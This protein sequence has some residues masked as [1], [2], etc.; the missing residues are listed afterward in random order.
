MAR[1]LILA[2]S[3]F[4][5]TTSIGKIPEFG[6]EGLSPEDTYIISVTSKPL[7]FKGSAT[8]FPIAPLSDLKQGRRVICKDAS[9]VAQ[10][11]NDLAKSPFKNVVWDD[12]NYVMQDWYMDNAL[13]KGW[14]A[15]KQIGFF[16]G[17]IFKAIE[18]YDGLGKNV[19]VLAHGEQTSGP[20]GRL[21]IKMK[22][23]GKMV[24]EYV[25]PE[26]KFDMTLLGVSRYDS[27]KKTVVKEFLTNENEQY[28]SAKSPIGMFDKLFIPND[29]GLV[30]KTVNEYYQ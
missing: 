20:D 7:P 14:D 6:I 2:P 25:T 15:P 13:S 12:A 18:Q 30:V 10:A 23:T 9:E 4:G 27:T 1:I 5:K 22:T 16:M 19:I 21:Y 28:S 17:K 3:G 24:D 26:G 8:M 29:L 11:L